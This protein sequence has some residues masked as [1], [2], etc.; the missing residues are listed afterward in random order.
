[1]KPRRAVHLL[2]GLDRTNFVLFEK[3]ACT[4]FDRDLDGLCPNLVHYA[5]APISVKKDSSS[6]PA[7]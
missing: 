5:L 7:P 4:L 6:I 1:M 3:Q 2:S